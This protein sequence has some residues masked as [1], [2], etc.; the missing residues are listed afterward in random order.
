M[1]ILSLWIG[2][3]S[4]IIL[5]RKLHYIYFYIKVSDNINYICISRLYEL[6]QKSLSVAIPNF[7]SLLSIHPKIQSDIAKEISNLTR[8]LKE[9]IRLDDLK[10]CTLLDAAVK[11]SLRLL[12]PF[13]MS[14]NRES[15]AD[16]YKL[17]GIIYFKK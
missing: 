11:E 10:N 16:V 2:M 1:K 6:G 9:P 14:F 5:K 4:R 7:L 12:P 17:P 15:T 8:S 13:P 3:K